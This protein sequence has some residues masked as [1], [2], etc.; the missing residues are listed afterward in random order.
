MIMKI[1]ERKITELIEADYNPRRLTETQ[2]KQLK[3]SLSTFGLVDPILVN[4]NEERKNIII[5]GHQRTKVWSDLGNDT[6]PCI[7]LN[8]SLDQEKELNV[9]LN[10]NTGEFDF[11]ML[12]NHFDEDNLV[13]WGFDAFQFDTEDEVDYSVLDD[14]DLD[15]ELEEM[16]SGVKKA[17]QIEFDLDRYEEAKELVKYWRDKEANIG[18][19]IIEFLKS[20]KLKL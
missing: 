12:A 20:E 1:V 10:K 6:I 17:I 5:G 8:L 4:I 13:E 19:M 2:Y 9:R 16:N 7:E 11:D 3:N 18:E 14:E 15:D